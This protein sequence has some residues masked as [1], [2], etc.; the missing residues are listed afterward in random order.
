MITTNIIDGRDRFRS[1]NSRQSDAAAALEKRIAATARVPDADKV[2]FAQ[3]L[4]KLAHR[5]D[6][7]VPLRGARLVVEQ[8]GLDSIWDKRKRFIRLPGEAAPPPIAGGDYGSSGATFVRLARAAGRLLAASQRPE[9]I[10]VECGM[11][12]R[13]LAI[14]TTFLPTYTPLTGPDR[15]AKDLLDDYASVVS[16]AISERTRL[17]DLWSVLQDASFGVRP[18]WE[19]EAEAMTIPP[20]YRLPEGFSES[21]FSSGI[22]D[23]VFDMKAPGWS[24]WAYPALTIGAIAIK[25]S[26]RLF[27]IPAAKAHLFDDIDENG[28][29][30]S[31]ARRWLRSTGI[32]EDSF[33]EDFAETLFDP[34]KGFGWREVTVSALRSVVLE[35]VKGREG[36]PNLSLAVPGG[37]GDLAFAEHDFDLPKAEELLLGP[38]NCS[39]TAL[40]SVGSETVVLVYGRPFNSQCPERPGVVGFLDFMWDDEQEISKFDEGGWTDESAMA[41]LLLG[42]EHRFYPNKPFSDPNGVPIH[43]GSIGAGLYSNLMNAPDEYRFD[44]LLIEQARITAEAGLGFQEALIEQSREALR[45]I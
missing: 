2:V 36:R 33:Y 3:N 43:R 17:E 31:A 41:A 39:Q 25:A 8:A 10:E 27:F 9:S 20:F 35:V 45:R 11:A 6:T 21:L 38:G 1:R 7:A 14:G 37:K 13:S 44:K 34:D 40:V 18:I 26:A 23:A 5:V 29:P 32:G 4:G 42:G 16:Q 30:S 28:Q 12:V 24:G 15:S 19:D 22:T